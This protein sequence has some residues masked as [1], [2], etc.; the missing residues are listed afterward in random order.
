MDVL[1][2]FSAKESGMKP[3]I[4]PIAL[5]V[6]FVAGWTNQDYKNKRL[7]LRVEAQELEIDALS[8][9]QKEIIN[10]QKAQKK[11]IL[12]SHKLHERALEHVK[13]LHMTIGKV[14]PELKSP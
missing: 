1:T 5:A 13:K 14:H 11:V 7:Q 9:K 10:E 6:F 3:Y 4:L 8:N 2:R 12:Q